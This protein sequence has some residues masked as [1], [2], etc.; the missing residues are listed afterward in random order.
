MITASIVD[1]LASNSLQQHMFASQS[2]V[3]QECLAEGHTCLFTYT[4]C[5]GLYCRLYD[6]WVP[7]GHC[8][9]G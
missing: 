4:C 3:A 1:R 9:V 2:T 6:D 5:D 8:R 7:D